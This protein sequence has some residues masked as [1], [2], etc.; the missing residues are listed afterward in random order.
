MAGVTK[1]NGKPLIYT[2]FADFDDPNRATEVSKHT[3]LEAFEASK[4]KSCVSGVCVYG[5]VWAEYQEV[6]PDKR[7]PFTKTR[8]FEPTLLPFRP[9]IEAKRRAMKE[10]PILN[11]MLQW[12]DCCMK[13]VHS[14]DDHVRTARH[15]RY[16]CIQ[17]P[18]LAI[19][20]FPWIKEAIAE[21]VLT[22][23]EKE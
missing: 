23:P 2:A 4:K 20:A 22:C 3:S 15:F 1:M 14:P 7:A 16:W 10:R 21:E 12:A 5:W 6:P 17:F 9:W 18:E 19:S 11:P 13:A 8:I